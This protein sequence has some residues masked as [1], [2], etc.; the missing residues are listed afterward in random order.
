MNLMQLPLP[1]GSSSR[2]SSGACF[3]ATPTHEGTVGVS[4]ERD[5]KPR[6][7]TMTPMHLLQLQCASSMSFSQS[8]STLVAGF[9]PQDSGIQELFPTVWQ[10]L[11]AEGAAPPK[12]KGKKNSKKSKP[13]VPAR[14]NEC[15]LLLRHVPLD[16]T[17]D[18]LLDELEGFLQFIDFYYLPVNFETRNNLG[19]AFVNF[20]DKGAA[21]RFKVF[22]EQ[23]GIP[24]SDEMPVQEARIQGYATNVDRFRNSSVMG[25]LSEER[26]P[27]VFCKGVQQVFPQPARELPPVGPRFRPTG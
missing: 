11:H 27:R 22:W 26:K 14:E 19:Y 3:D 9:M 8:A 13:V 25:V 10:P 18:S 23:S 16:Y 17:P 7:T 15:T 24:E 4:F 12:K 6:S 21:A 2:L 1:L 20:C 5:S